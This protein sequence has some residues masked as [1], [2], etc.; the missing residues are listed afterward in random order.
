MAFA[1]EPEVSHA[2]TVFGLV[3]RI[4][5]LSISGIL[6]LG[7]CVTS[8]AWYVLDRGASRAATERV[9]TNLRVAWEVLGSKGKDF[10]IADGKLLRNGQVLNGDTAIVDKVKSL[11]GGT[12]TIFMNESLF[13][14]S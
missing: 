1:P 12:C 4:M 5:L 7:I 14:N 8:V 3:P 10:S 11:V 2:R 13:E 9:E 6:A